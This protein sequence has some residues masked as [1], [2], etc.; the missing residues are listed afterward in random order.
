[1]KR[2]DRGRGPVQGPARR[3]RPGV[4]REHR[5]GP[6]QDRGVLRAR[7][8]PPLPDRDG[9][10][11]TEWIAGRHAVHAALMALDRGAAAPALTTS[12]GGGHG[13]PRAIDR[14]VVSDDLGVQRWWRS[15]MADLARRAGVLVSLAPRTALDRIVRGVAHQGVAARVAA[16]ATVSLAEILAAAHAPALVVL[17]DGVEDPR[18]LGAII[19]SAAAAGADGVVLP[20]RRSAGLSAACAKAAAGAL[21]RVAVARIVNAVRAIEEMKAAGLW[22]V[23]LDARGRDVWSGGVDLARPT[24]LVVGSEDR[25][26]SRLVR[27]ACDDLL[28]LPLAAG[29]QSLNASVAAGIALYEIVRQRRMQQHAMGTPGGGTAGS[30][31]RNDSN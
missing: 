8:Q 13:T 15:E 26:I 2:R 19:R 7:P 20:E 4:P 23:G 24:C 25:G 30:Q 18:N 28:A 3:E 21:E 6:R 5:E 16:K 22:A 17:A 1:V 9:D 10:A 31:R 29:I 11:E 27:E 14:V 12:P